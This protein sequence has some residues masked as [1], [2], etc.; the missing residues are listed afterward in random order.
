MD[1]EILHCLSRFEMVSFSA[2]FT[3]RC[4]FTIDN[5][6]D[7]YTFLTPSNGPVA[8]LTIKTQ[9][10]HSNFLL[11]PSTILHLTFT[12]FVIDQLLIL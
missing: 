2:F 11:T 12:H 1:V 8:A 5:L 10:Q 9:Q 3:Y 6:A 7:D 4:P